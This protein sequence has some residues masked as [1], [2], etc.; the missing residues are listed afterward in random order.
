[1]GEVTLAAI[2]IGTLKTKFLIARI[3]ESGQLEEIYKSNTLTC[4]G[5]DMNRNG[6]FV[7]KRNLYDTINELHRCNELLAEYS[8]DRVR[9][10]STHALRKAK[11]REYVLK[12]IKNRVGFKVENISQA[13][14]ASLFFNVVL[15]DFAK[16]KRYA[17]T[18][19]GGGSVQLL[20]GKPGELEQMYLLP[21]GSQYLHATFTKDSDNELACTT[22]KDIENMRNYILE[23]LL[24]IEK[25]QNTPIVYGSSNVIDLMQTINIPLDSNDDSQVH[26]YKTYAK[27]LDEF[28]E[29]VLPL[30]YKERESQYPFQ[31]GYMWGIDKAFTTISTMS[32]YLN[33]PHIIPSNANISQGIIYSMKPQTVNL[34][35]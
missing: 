30:S 34:A 8:V 26:P 19:I 27:Y 24:P 5:C 31:Y 15:R 22:E 9:I 14:E 25:T 17:V 32:Q 28:T 12:M 20:I 29:R 21:M 13:E 10:V 11:N 1:M 35:G 16:D 4:L 6:G 3:T 33:A 18:D 2:D 7:S 23:Q